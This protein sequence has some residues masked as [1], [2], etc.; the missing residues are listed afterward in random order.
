[1]VTENDYAN[2]VNYAVTLAKKENKVRQAIMLVLSFSP[3]NLNLG[4]IRLMTPKKAK[5][6]NDDILKSF[7]KYL[8]DKNNYTDSVY[9]LGHHNNTYRTSTNAGLKKIARSIFNAAP[10][11]IQDILAKMELSEYTTDPKSGS[12]FVKKQMIIGLP[13]SNYY[14]YVFKCEDYYKIGYT[15]SIENRISA[16]K[17]SNPFPVTVL[18]VWCF[19]KLSQAT[20]FEADLHEK[21]QHRRIHG[22][23]FKLLINE[24]EEIKMDSSFQLTEHIKLV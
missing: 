2:I 23:W 20:A 8:V 17:G 3:L 16:I 11:N 14:V 10:K 7:C 22:E 5:L 9:L 18:G 21:F 19:D 1:M 12:P 13:E 15:R 6:T 4:Q 24:L